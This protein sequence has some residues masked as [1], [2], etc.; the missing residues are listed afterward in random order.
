MS[1]KITF[2]ELIDSISE[3]TNHSK[4]FT[5][6]FLK[7]FVSII[8]KGLEDDGTVNIAGFGKFELRRMREREGFNPQT[9]EKITIPAH[10]KA[11]FKPFKQLRE[12][13]NAPYS[14]LEPD[15]IKEK[16]EASPD[17]PGQNS[18]DPDVQEMPEPQ[19]N[20]GQ[21]E[22]HLQNQEKAPWE[23]ALEGEDHHKIDS[24]DPFG[25][26]DQESMRTSFRFDDSEEETS[27]DD[28]TDDSDIVEYTPDIDNDKPLPEELH[29]QEIFDS[30]A[31]QASVKDDS[32]TNAP[33]TEE[34]PDKDFTTPDIFDSA[35]ATSETEKTRALL[36][37]DKE[38][39]PLEV[40]RQKIAL[41]PA[42]TQPH[43]GRAMYIRY[44]AAVLGLLI[45]FAGAWYLSGFGTGNYLTGM[46][47]TSSSAPD[48]GNQVAK[49]T[50]ND[51][52]T[53][54]VGPATTQNDRQ[55]KP[56][57]TAP[58]LASDAR[59]RKTA[60]VIERGQTLWSLA[61]L[62]YD[63][64]YLWPWIF[65]TNKASV[66]NPHHIL[67]GQTLGIPV[68]SGTGGQLN[69]DDSLQVAIG[70]VES[71]KWHKANN[72]DNAKYYLFAAKI[73]DGNVFQHTDVNI[74]KA[75]LMFADKV[76]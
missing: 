47:V 75:D 58:G 39:Y 6:E 27:Q 72:Y 59:E 50:P 2:Q 11:A 28:L 25:F 68:P 26:V 62:R 38:S 8:H 65:D 52:S 43:Q 23:R 31:S 48:G 30:H 12:I 21:T 73:Y 67:A 36:T 70:Y 20:P 22:H 45:V 69:S 15:L 35:S 51:K 74:D 4:Q 1:E 63:D 24:D 49:Q 44:A 71:Y 7:D 5:H 60:L 61:K 53:V 64:P 34:Y 54:P 32:S 41:S 57:T 66:S 29:A 40:V 19:D 16:P 56:S 46:A 55:P 33:V 9:G 76:R 18:N 13:V 42:E 37:S 14:H 17:A 3:K 10:N